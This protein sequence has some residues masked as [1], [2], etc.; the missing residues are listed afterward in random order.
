MKEIECENK[1]LTCERTQERAST[2]TTIQQS[3]EKDQKLKA[4]LSDKEKQLVPEID[5]E[6]QQTEEENRET[7]ETK[8]RTR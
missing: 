7:K 2:N 3:Q 1:R 8:I 6:V 4:E 5:T